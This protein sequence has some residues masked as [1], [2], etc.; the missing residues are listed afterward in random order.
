MIREAKDMTNE[1]REQMRG[2]KGSVE[3]LHLF[4]EEELRGKSRLCARIRLEPGASIGMHEHLNEEEI[5]YILSGRGLVNDN[6]NL[7]E[8]TAGDAVLTGGGAAHSIENI[9]DEILEMM[10]I[11]LLF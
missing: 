1:I 3:I 7:S 4:K 5:Y 8:V 10:A 2:G 6:G 11:V 9:G